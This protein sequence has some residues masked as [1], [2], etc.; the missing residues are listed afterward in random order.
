M[1]AQLSRRTLLL[2]VSATA[3]ASAVGWAGTRSPA[4]GAVPLTAHHQ[5]GALDRS[6]FHYATGD[7]GYAASAGRRAQT[8][9]RGASAM[10][11]REIDRFSRAFTWAVGRGYLDVFNDE[12]F[13]HMRHRQHGA[14]VL[15]QAPPA[16]QAGEFPTWGFR[17]LPWHRSFLMEA[18]AMLRAALYDRN[19][20]ERR[21]PREADLLFLPYWD[22]AHDQDLPR[23]VRRLQPRGGT[24]IVPPDLPPGHAGYGKPVGSRYRIRFLR[25]PGGWPVFDRLPPIDQIGRI[26]DRDDYGTFYSGIDLVPEIV[27]TQIP[28]ARRSLAALALRLPDDPNLQIILAAT[29]PAYPKNPEAQL[30]AFNALLAV[31]HIA[32]WELAK[33][34]PDLELVRLIR[35]VY[36]VFRFQP[37]ILLHFWAGGL[38]R[39]NPDVRGTVTYFN[40]LCVDPVFWMLHGELDR[41]WYTWEG[42]H[43]GVPPPLTGD[44]A[45]FQPIR[46]E[47]GAWYGGG[48]TYHVAD[49]VDHGGLTYRYDAL[50][51]V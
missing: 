8:V 45:E 5:H 11:P 9:R 17:L 24:A 37:H 20:H 7:P 22:A 40:E 1:T 36:S 47:D 10:S 6:G 19:R 50:F 16:V 41:Y 3:A 38:D 25:R 49:L 32:S 13:D 12:H 51:T 46:P 34:S 2:G 43:P 39:R 44:N 42:S 28:E 23:W 31:G 4:A 15:A 33:R 48:R 18:E 14:D 35:S 27:E 30:A 21:D 26:L 29:D